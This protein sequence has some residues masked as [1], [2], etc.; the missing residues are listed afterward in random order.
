[1]PDNLP[2]RHKYKQTH[3]KSSHYLF[4]AEESVWAN[5]K[6]TENIKFHV[7]AACIWSTLL[8]GHIP[9]AVFH[10]LFGELESGKI[11]G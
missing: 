4:K 6:L 11:Y 8:Y 1:M 7:Y 2:L 5:S 10:L 3:W 9:K